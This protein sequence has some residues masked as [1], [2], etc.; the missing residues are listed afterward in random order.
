[1]LDEEIVALYHCRDESAIT[2][3]EEKYHPYLMKI[4]R[5]ILTLRE[6]CEESVNDTYLAAWN[7]MPP[8][9]P[10]VLSTYLGKLTRRIAITRYRRNNRKKRQAS[11]YELSLNELSEVADFSD[12]PETAAEAAELAGLLNTFVRALSEEERAVFIGRYYFLDPLREVADYC[13]MSESKAKS[14]LHRIRLRLKEYL[15]QEGFFV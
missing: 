8:H 11:Q 2:A 3:T 14:M 9:K 1:M 10:S 7:S 6:D 12:S 5:N 4:A 13:G 15:E